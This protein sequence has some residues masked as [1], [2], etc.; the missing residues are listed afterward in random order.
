MPLSFNL[1]RAGSVFPAIVAS[2]ALLI[3]SVPVTAGQTYSY[4]LPQQG[5]SQSRAR[6][7]KVYVPENLA[8]PAPMVMALHGCR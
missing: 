4:T 5:Y 7:Y 6:D 8:T 2:A 1:R 3:Q